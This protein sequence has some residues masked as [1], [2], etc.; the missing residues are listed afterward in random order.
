MVNWLHG[1]GHKFECQLQHCGRYQPDAGCVVGEQCEHLFSLTKV[2]HCRCNGLRGKPV[3]QPGA[4]RCAADG[5]LMVAHCCAQ[6]LA[7]PSRYMLL[8]HRLGFIEAGLDR[9]AMR[10]QEQMVDLL[11][12]RLK[13]FTTT[14][15]R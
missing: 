2:G 8:A 4:R 3:V 7:P 9:I 6:P 10:R 12:R 15:G 14:I 5:P 11:L 1:A 13:R